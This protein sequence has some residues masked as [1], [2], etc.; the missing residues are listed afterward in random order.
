MDT[1]KIW[2]ILSLDKQYAAGRIAA[3]CRR[4]L[5]LDSL[6]YRTVK[7]FLELEEEERLA[8]SPQGTGDGARPVSTA[9]RPTTHKYGRPLSVYQEQLRL[10]TEE[11][12][13]EERRGIALV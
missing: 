1:R 12:P 4:A 6:S 3:A 13:A 5:E 7:G 11:G 10:F 8:R 2:G 9:I